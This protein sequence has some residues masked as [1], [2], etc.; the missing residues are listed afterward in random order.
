MPKYK[1]SE[2]RESS[3]VELV[4]IRVFTFLIYK[5]LQKLFFLQMLIHS[6]P[7]DRFWRAMTSQK[8]IPLK[9][10][11]PMAFKFLFQKYQIDAREGMQKW[12]RY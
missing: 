6:A 12:P 9:N 3:F 11:E 7:F 8:S 10:L 1:V 5:L 2:V 4:I